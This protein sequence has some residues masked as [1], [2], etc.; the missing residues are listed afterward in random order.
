MKTDLGHF[1]TQVMDC[2]RGFS[3]EPSSGSYNMASTLSPPPT[4]YTIRESTASRPVFTE[5]RSTSVLVHL[6]TTN[7]YLLTT[8]TAT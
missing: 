1:S 2:R 6:P 8:H 5:L 7:T 4:P 3:L